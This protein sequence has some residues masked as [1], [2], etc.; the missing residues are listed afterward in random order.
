MS[1]ILVIQAAF[2]PD[3]AQK[4]ADAAKAVLDKAHCTYE[5][6]QVPG[7]F[8]IPAALAIAIASKRY[9]GYVTLGCVIRGE[10]SHYDYVCAESARG[11]NSLAYTHRVAVG[12]GIITADT[13]KQVIARCKPNEHNVAA[14]A[15]SACLTMIDIQHKMVVS[16]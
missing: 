7:C 5:L 8:E 16:I 2:Y 15:A 4:M 6:I 10:T 13:H 11:I 14:R 1:H 12:Y 9:D 3:I